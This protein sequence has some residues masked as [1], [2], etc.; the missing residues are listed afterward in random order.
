VLGAG[1]HD[2]LGVL[3]EGSQAVGQLGCLLGRERAVLGRALDED[4]S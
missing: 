2:H 3:A 1:V 4:G